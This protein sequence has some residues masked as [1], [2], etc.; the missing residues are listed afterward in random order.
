MNH[1]PTPDT[2]VFSITASFLSVQTGLK[3]YLL[4]FLVR[5]QD[6]EDVVQETFLRAYESEKSQTI[7]SPR[8]FL[9]K[10]A[11]NLALNELDRKSAQL[12]SYVGDM[13]AL[14]LV[15][16]GP[17]VE[18]DIEQQQKL[19]ACTV[20]MSSLSKQCRRALVMRKVF[21]F[22]HKEIARR[23][24]IS[25]RTVEKHLAKALQRCQ[26]SVQAADGTRGIEHRKEKKIGRGTA[27]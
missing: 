6:I 27:A 25:V 26:Q 3:Q 18:D 17:S 19:A 22:S 9:F 15:D 4:R 7:R 5:R 8:S 24:D 21:G 2:D 16:R 11:R 1:S 12:M 23:M 14:P 13:E 10:V 20:A